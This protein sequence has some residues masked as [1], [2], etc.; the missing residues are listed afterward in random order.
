MVHEDKSSMVDIYQVFENMMF[1]SKQIIATL[2]LLYSIKKA[3]EVTQLTH[4][5]TI[6]FSGPHW[7]TGKNHLW[8][9]QTFSLTKLFQEV[10]K[11]I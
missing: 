11:T 5:K 3:A 9:I 4:N 8:C 2:H 7:Y 1:F 6:S 10:L